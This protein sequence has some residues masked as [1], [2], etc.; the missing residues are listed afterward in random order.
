MAVIARRC[1]T[2]AKGLVE[3]KNEELI[4]L[5]VN[6][7][8]FNHRIA[9]AWAFGI[10]KEPTDCLLRLLEDRHPLVSLAAHESCISIA[11]T[12]YKDSVDFGPFETDAGGKKSAGELWAV[13][14]ERKDKGQ[15]IAKS[16][17]QILGVAEADKK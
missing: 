6:S 16:P 13:Y 17:A 2:M 1:M 7:T 3:Q 14:F 5:S 8:D 9:A 15:P 4:E 10:R 11:K 12:R